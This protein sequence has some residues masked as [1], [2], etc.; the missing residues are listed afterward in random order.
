MESLGKESD[1]E[2]Y[3]YL[4][5]PDSEMARRF[6]MMNR[7]RKASDHVILICLR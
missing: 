3:S 7:V 1:G 6:N 4:D 5:D 2:I